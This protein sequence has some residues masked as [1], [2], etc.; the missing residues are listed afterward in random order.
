MKER[1]EKIN[2]KEFE[3]Y[4]RIMYKENFNRLKKKSNQDEK[5]KKK[6]KFFLNRKRITP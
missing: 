2:P 4:V 6:K 5:S 3:E 1:K